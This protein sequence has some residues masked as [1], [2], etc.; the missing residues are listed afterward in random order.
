[1]EKIADSIETLLKNK[2]TSYQGLTELLTQERDAIVDMDVASLWEAS[3]RKK[4][5]AKNIESLRNSILYLF[6]QEGIE[7]SMDVGSFSLA[8]LLT[9]VSFSKPE[10]LALGALKFA[11]DKEKAEVARLSMENQNHVQE[12]LEVVE[13]LVATLLPIPDNG[14]YGWTGSE[15]SPAKANCFIS[16]EV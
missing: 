9:L 16:Q 3:N 12:R 1:M 10:K 6:E 2:L 11:I 5:I 8:Q 14:W 7:H 15:V 13:G 4:K